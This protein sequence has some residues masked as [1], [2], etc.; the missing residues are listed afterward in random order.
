MMYL[1]MN[2]YFRSLMT[3]FEAVIHPA[4]GFSESG[5]EK[6]K[7]RSVRFQAET[8]SPDSFNMRASAKKQDKG[9]RS[10]AP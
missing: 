1:K 6:R 5:P 8:I 3:Y 9:R 10:P 7:R 4:S 2:S